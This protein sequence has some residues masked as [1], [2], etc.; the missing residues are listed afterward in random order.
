MGSA[1][2]FFKEEYA[3]GIEAESRVQIRAEASVEV[4]SKWKS[5]GKRK[6]PKD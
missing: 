4:L 5:S 3:I 2:A 1:I 6:Y